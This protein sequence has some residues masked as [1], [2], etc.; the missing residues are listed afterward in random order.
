MRDRRSTKA[1]QAVTTQSSD[2]RVFSCYRLCDVIICALI[3]DAEVVGVCDGGSG[4]SQLQLKHA[5][6]TL[7][8]FYREVN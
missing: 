4:K 5:V 8:R 6:V 7:A 3:L 1:P 2:S